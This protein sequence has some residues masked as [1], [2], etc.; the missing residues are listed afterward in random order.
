LV[1]AGALSGAGQDHLLLATGLELPGDSCCDGRMPTLNRRVAAAI[2]GDFVVF[3]IGARINRWWK[4]WKYLWFGS[5]MPKMIA[6]LAAKPESGFLGADR[7]G[8]ANLV[9][10]NKENRLQRRHRYLA[11]DLHDPR[12]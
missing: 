6:E 3:L 11:R 10:F 1:D 7:L 4:L 2:E 12:R 9:Q 8:F 5:T